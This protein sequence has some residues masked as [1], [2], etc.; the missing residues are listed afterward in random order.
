MLGHSK[1]RIGKRQACSILNQDEISLF[2]IS[3]GLGL[4][5]T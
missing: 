4:I 5:F 3:Q 1:C 2:W